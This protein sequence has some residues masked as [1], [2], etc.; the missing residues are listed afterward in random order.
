MSL[1][2]GIILFFKALGFL[3]KNTRL[4]PYALLPALVT[5]LVSLGSITLILIYGDEFLAYAAPQYFKNQSGWLASFSIWM[6]KL[7]LNALVF[8][9][10][11]FLV[12]L[13][14]FPLC[15]PLAIKCDDI[16]GGKELEVGLF[17]GITRSF[18]VSIMVVT[19]GLFGSIALLFLGFIPIIGFLAPAFQILIWTPFLLCFDLCDS[20]FARRQYPFKERFG[21]LSQNLTKTIGIGLIA[22]FCVSIPFL[23]LLTLPIAIVMGIMYAREIE[24]EKEL[25]G[26]EQEKQ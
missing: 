22:S 4:I 13:V 15:E 7:A 5:L 10:I 24:Q 12:M 9:L 25:L 18:S 23:N 8:F 3:L 11:P 6:I 26:I 14:A 1:F 20:L 21:L 16:L 2:H 17:S 19:F